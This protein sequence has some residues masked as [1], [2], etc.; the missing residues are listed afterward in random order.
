MPLIYNSTKNALFLRNDRKS[1]VLWKFIRNNPLRASSHPIG[2][3]QIAGSTSGSEL[4]IS[5]PGLSQDSFPV[6]S[7]PD[8]GVESKKA[9]DP[10]NHFVWTVHIGNDN[11]ISLN[12]SLLGT[13]CKIDIRRGIVVDVGRGVARRIHA[14]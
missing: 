5:I 11:K 13:R 6:L 7:H 3:V 4:T 10:L 2:I 12:Q 8:A 14:S 1:Q 9:H